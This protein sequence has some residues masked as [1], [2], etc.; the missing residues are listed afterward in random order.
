M[1]GTLIAASREKNES[2]AS[3]RV[4][5]CDRWFSRCLGNHSEYRN[6]RI[7]DQRSTTEL[8]RHISR[9]TQMLFINTIGNAT[10]YWKTNGKNPCENIRK[11]LFDANMEFVPRAKIESAHDG[12]REW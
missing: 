4:R 12:N 8:K 2:T 6:T 10:N 5:T 3:Y 1:K 11:I 7:Q 9:I